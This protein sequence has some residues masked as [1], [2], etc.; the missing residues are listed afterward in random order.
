MFMIPIKGG[1]KEFS[2]SIKMDSDHN[3]VDP[4]NRSTL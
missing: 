3:T 4:F 1:S 2:K